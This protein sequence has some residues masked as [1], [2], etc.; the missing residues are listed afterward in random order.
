MRRALLLVLV[1]S[2]T[3]NTG[4]TNSRLDSSPPAAG[5][6]TKVE[7]NRREL[8]EPLGGYP[9]DREREMQVYMNLSRHSLKT[10]NGNECSD[11][12]FDLDGGSIKKTPFVYSREANIAARFTARHL[13]EIGCIQPESCCVLGDAGVGIGCVAPGACS[14]NVC[15]KT[16]DAGVD[17]TA[18]ARYALF[19]FTSYTHQVIGLDLS[20]YDLWCSMNV[21]PSIYARMTDD[22]GTQFASGEFQ[23]AA[24]TCDKDYWAVA[25]GNAQV[26]VP[27]IPAAA[28][29]YPPPQPLNTSQLSFM[30]TYFDPSG[31]PPQR[32][33]VVVAGHCFDLDRTYGFDDNGTYVASFPD[34]D[35]LP[36]GCH[37][38]Y[39]L[40]QD[41]DGQRVTYPTTG[42]FQLPLGGAQSCPLAYDSTSQLPAD[43]ETG[44]QMCPM[45]ATQNCYVADTSTLGKGECRQGYQVCKQ[46]FWSA[47]KDMIGP[48]PEICDG[49]DNDC[50]GQTDE[51]NPGGASSCNVIEEAGQCRSGTQVC[52]SGRL[53]CISI[54]GPEPEVCDGIDNDCDNAID[55]GFNKQTCGVGECFRLLDTCVN[56][57]PQ[58]PCDAGTGTAE[59]EDGKDNN[60]NGIVDEGFPCTGARSIYPSSR[61][62][63]DGGMMTQLI[64]PCR[65]GTQMCNPDGGWG[66]V[67][68][69]VVPK[70]EECNGF[71]DDCDGQFDNEAAT[72]NQIGRSRCGIG[73]CKRSV[74]DCR[75][76]RLLGCDAGAPSEEICDGKDNNCNGTLDEQCSCRLGEERLCYTGPSPTRDAGV[77]H[78]G[79]RSCVDG[80]YTRCL[81]EVKPSAEY[82]NG[83]DDDCDGVIDEMCLPDAGGGTG[84]GSG[85]GSG[86]AGGSAGTGGGSGTGG[87]MEGGGGCKCSSLGLEPMLLMAFAAVL[88]RRRQRG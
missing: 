6:P 23:N 69:A 22:A 74:Y 4:P 10:P 42:S 37:P 63:P 46:G 71:D 82:C 18:A 70:P 27:R 72:L 7:V 25:F 41:A 8:G 12:S 5:D 59:V 45:G 52:T 29:V 57:V 1:V 28:A 38:Y 44:V 40:F 85:G 76:N 73:E 83:F 49:L 80:G 62:L 26:Q 84:G 78:G 48:F 20:A 36:D 67:F 81:G 30:A 68:G 47:C 56:G 39:F 2:C 61:Q 54:Q 31:R 14:G 51:N 11:P 13:S 33:V 35:V 88:R 65:N 64:M 86:T 43:C 24:A 32:S 21:T 34:P 55:D 75:G 50:D 16:C 3:T 66:P 77:C 58:P 9:S 60:C 53:T 87:G 79:K 19:G 17:Q 15:Q